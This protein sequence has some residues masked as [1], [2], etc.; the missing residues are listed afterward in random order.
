MSQQYAVIPTLESR[1]GALVQPMLFTFELDGGGAWDDLT[2]KDVRLR[3]YRY[4]TLAFEL[5]H[6]D[7][8]VTVASDSITLSPELNPVLAATAKAAGS[9][10]R[11]ATWG[12]LPPLEYSFR[13][14]VTDPGTDA[15]LGIVATWTH[16]TAQHVGATLAP[17]G[18]TIT[19]D[20]EGVDVA[21]TISL[22][23][24]GGGGTDDQTAAEV[25]FT[26]TGGIAATDVQAAIAELDSEKAAASN[27]LL[28]TRK[29]I[30]GSGNSSGVGFYRITGSSVT[31]TF[32]SA[33]IANSL[34]VV[35]V[36]NETAT[37]ATLATQGAETIEGLATLSL[38]AGAS[39]WLYSDGSNLR[40]IMP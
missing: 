9:A 24:G 20:T 12:V 21:V 6:D 23:G 2:G 17:S 22:A 34:L 29:V 31:L 7:D 28:L 37:T 26:P 36:K 32:T 30:A 3:W 4:G 10:A 18:S 19:V 25:P 16:Q 39:V 40:Q 5:T 15:E 1:V 38:F 33:D 14:D 35:A 13:L 27:V 11:Y 8:E